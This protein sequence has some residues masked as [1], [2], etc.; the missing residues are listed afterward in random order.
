M[1]GGGIAG[2]V[3]GVLIGVAFAIVGGWLLL[4]R[5]RKVR[6]GRAPSS[7]GDQDATER[8]ALSQ[9]EKD[10]IP[11]SEMDGVGRIG[12]VEGAPLFE[13]YARPS[14][15]EAEYMAPQLST[16]GIKSPV[17]SMSIKTPGL[18]SLS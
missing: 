11:L 9:E 1:S 8:T 13:M 17:G 15:L 18:Q 7:V 6:L 12:E 14:E 3:V 4:R 2:I 16:K 10:G 5:W